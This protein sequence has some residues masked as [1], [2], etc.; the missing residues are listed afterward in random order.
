MRLSQA[1]LEQIAARERFRAM[2]EPSAPPEKLTTP[3]RFAP[4]L[5]PVANPNLQAAPLFNPLGKSYAPLQSGISR[6][7][8][9]TPLP[10]LTTPNLQPATPKKTLVD[11]PPW[12]SDGPQPF[13]SQ[14]RRF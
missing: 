11:P 10:S 5:A 6:P 12:L 1:N 2:M 13:G 14:T 7:A 8:G 4:A 9:I 3:T